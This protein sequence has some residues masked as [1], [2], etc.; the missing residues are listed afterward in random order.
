MNGLGVKRQLGA[1]VV[2][3]KIKLQGLAILVANTIVVGVF[4]T[5]FVKQFGRPFRVVGVGVFQ[6]VKAVVERRRH[7]G[8]AGNEGSF[9]EYLVVGFPV[10]AANEGGANLRI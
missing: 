5:G 4:P 7:R 8:A 3:D 2:N 10:A 6:L 1:A 9:Q